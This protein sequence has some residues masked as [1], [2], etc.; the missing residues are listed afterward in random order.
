MML[1]VTIR[2]NNFCSFCQ[3]MGVATSPEPTIHFSRQSTL[4]RQR[5]WIG[6]ARPLRL[7]KREIACD[8]AHAARVHVEIGF[9]T[10][11]VGGQ[12][13]CPDLARQGFHVAL[14]FSVE[15]DHPGEQFHDH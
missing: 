3:L 8:L 2:L 6:L 9:L 12:A 1:R 5:T 13:A 4:Q 7:E 10:L 14:G 11:Q 15:H